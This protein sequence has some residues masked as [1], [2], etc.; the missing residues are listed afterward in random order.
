[1]TPPS[2]KGEAWTPGDLR[3]LATHIEALT[4]ASNTLDVLVEVALFERDARTVAVRPNAAGTKVIYT[5]AIGSEQTHWAYDW[6]ITAAARAKTVAGLRARA[7]R[8]AA[9]SL[10]GEEGR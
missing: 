6:T 2:S 10:N 9:L 3:N 5:T 4:T 7:E 8:S 1:M